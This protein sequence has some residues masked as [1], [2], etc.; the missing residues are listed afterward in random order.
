LQTKETICAVGSDDKSITTYTQQRPGMA[1]KFANH[2][3]TSGF[4]Q[5]V[6]FTRNGK[7]LVAGMSDG[8]IELFLEG[9]AIGPVGEKGASGIL[10]LN[11]DC[12]TDD[13]FVV[14]S[15]SS[16]QSVK[17]WRVSI[18]DRL[19]TAELVQEAKPGIKSGAV[20]AGRN[21]IT[22]ALSGAMDVLSSETLQ[23]LR[24]AMEGH[25]KGIVDMVVIAGHLHSCSYDGKLLRWSDSCT[26]AECLHATQF[27]ANR[28]CSTQSTNRV[29]LLN[30]FEGK[31]SDGMQL[32]GLKEIVGIDGD[33]ALSR[34]GAFVAPERESGLLRVAGEI[35]HFCKS[36]TELFVASNATTLSSFS[37]FE[38][39]NCVKVASPITAMSVSPD[40]RLVAVADEQRRIRLYHTG[41]AEALSVAQKTHWC[42]HSSRI[43][44]LLWLTADVLASGGVDGDLITW[45]VRQ[46]NSPL[47]VIKA[48]HAAPITRLSRGTRDATDGSAGAF[49][50]ASAD[51]AIR[52]WAEQV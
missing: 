8:A 24:P 5:A 40:G 37:G 17:K 3:G 12:V 25:A 21:L 29:A 38:L 44:Q 9:S 7:Y 35:E 49:F 14:I 50:S 18:K 46:P 16:D 52:Q 23:A 13:D 10:S 36:N 41:V 1:F 39:K 22:V 2:A 4:V 42:H 28:I 51:G 11:V 45:H 26:A 20:L 15:T 33:F 27:A 19:P 32:G 34:K 48:A 31:T 30:C 43:D 47:Q 6:R